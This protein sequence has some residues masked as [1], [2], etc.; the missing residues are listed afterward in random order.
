MADKNSSIQIGQD[1]SQRLVISKY[2]L[3]AHIPFGLDESQIELTEPESEDAE[4]IALEL[5]EDEPGPK[6]GEED[7]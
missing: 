4:E 2:P 1:S 3:T 5:D 7:E 6:E